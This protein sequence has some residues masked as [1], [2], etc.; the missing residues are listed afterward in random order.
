V[1]EDVLETITV[2]LT[3]DVAE[4]VVQAIEPVSPANDT[5][6]AA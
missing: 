6:A 3:T 4:L 5:R 1:S 2:I